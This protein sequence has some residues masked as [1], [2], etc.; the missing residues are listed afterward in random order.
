M[1]AVTLEGLKRDLSADQLERCIGEAREQVTDVVQDIQALSHRLHS[2]KLELLGLAAAA[3]SFC[4]EF[5][6]RQ[7][8]EI[9]F[10]STDFPKNLAEAISLCLYRVLQEAL[11]NA[12]KHSGSRQFQVS[13]SSGTNE[14]ELT[15]TDSGV[16]FAPSEAIKWQGLGL[17]N[18]KE[19]LKLVDGELSIDSQLQRGTTVHAR[20]PLTPK[21][22]AAKAGE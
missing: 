3:S 12:A 6:N 16:G 19:R 7:N 1:L 17:T 14:I 10:R 4:K 11:Q 22:R 20:V 21:T 5:S 8:V 9:D 2:P 15:V 18:M 13:L